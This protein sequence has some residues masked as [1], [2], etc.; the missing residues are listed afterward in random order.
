MIQFQRSE[1]FFLR[2]NQ[3]AV[4]LSNPIPK[5]FDHHDKTIRYIEWTAI[6]FFRF[7]RDYRLMYWS[8]PKYERSYRL[9]QDHFANEAKAKPKNVKQQLY[10]RIIN[11]EFKSLDEVYVE[12]RKL[13][14]PKDR[15]KSLK[16][17]KQKTA[18]RSFAKARDGK[19]FIDNNALISSAKNAAQELAF[20]NPSQQ[21]IAKTAQKLIHI[22]S[23]QEDLS[24]EQISN[25]IE[26]IYR[27]VT[28]LEALDRLEAIITK[29]RDKNLLF[30]WVNIKRHYLVGE[31]MV[32][33][34]TEWSQFVGC[35]NAIVPDL[36]KSLVNLG[37]L[38]RIQ[39][40]K[41]GS[42]IGRANSYKR[43]I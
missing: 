18:Q 41:Q 23:P 34:Q 15:G 32:K 35:R 9:W 22:H 29:K 1:N 14:K 38:R 3:K 30:L 5:Y 2:E 37:A 42:T 28:K 19:A 24:G 20:T 27:R 8:Y 31:T 36:F 11:A 21:K 7:N 4:H 17:V 39:K 6:R 13:V 43:I 33:S 12:L 40:G 26:L 25:L 16:H 10:L